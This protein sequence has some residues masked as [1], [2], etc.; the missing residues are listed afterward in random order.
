M[1]ASRKLLE[2]QIVRLAAALS[3]RDM[4]TIARLS[5]DIT[6]QFLTN[7]EDTKGNDS[8]AFNRE[9]IQN[10]HNRTNEIHQVTVSYICNI[11]EFN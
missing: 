1:A 11:K 8:N 9:I 2:P 3:M 5:F 7:L 4:K 6:V 10:W